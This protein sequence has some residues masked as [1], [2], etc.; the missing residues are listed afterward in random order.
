MNK[1]FIITKY[2]LLSYDFF[3]LIIIIKL[4]INFFSKI[5]IILFEFLKL[6]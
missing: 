4:K 6:L 3:T 2:Y 1:N 5:V